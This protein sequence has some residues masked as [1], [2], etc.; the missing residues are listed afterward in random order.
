METNGSS[1]SIDRLTFPGEDSH[2]EPC[3]ETRS[4]KKT[5]NFRL[6]SPVLLQDQSPMIEA[7]PAVGVGVSI[8][9]STDASGCKEKVFV[10]GVPLAT[11]LR[12]S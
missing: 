9:I 1:R 7:I 6:Q 12:R 4:A 11:S 10:Q 5:K 8:C 3:A 2:V